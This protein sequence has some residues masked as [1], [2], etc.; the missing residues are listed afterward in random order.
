MLLFGKAGYTNAR[1]V[2]EYDDS[3]GGIHERFGQNLDGIRV[4]AGAQFGIGRNAYFR[5]EARYSNYEGGG[6]RGALLGAFGFRF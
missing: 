5:T 4:G 2:Q 3:A 6:D 1:Y